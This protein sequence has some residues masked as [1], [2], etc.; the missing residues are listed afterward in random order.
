MDHNI[1]TPKIIGGIFILLW[2]FKVFS[3]Q[4][5]LFLYFYQKKLTCNIDNKMPYCKTLPLL[6]NRQNFDEKLRDDKK[7]HFSCML[8]KT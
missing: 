6:T 5:T 2:L 7:I 4:K 1:F 3:C 8:I